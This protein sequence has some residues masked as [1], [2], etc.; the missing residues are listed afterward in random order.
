[1]GSLRWAKVYHWIIS[2]NTCALPA[3]RQGS[4][5]RLH[6]SQPHHSLLPYTHSHTPTTL[7]LTSLLPSLP[8]PQFSAHCVM[9][10]LGK[11]GSFPHSAAAAVAALLSRCRPSDTKASSV[12]HAQSDLLPGLARLAE[13]LIPEAGGCVQEARKLLYVCKQASELLHLLCNPSSHRIHRSYS[14]H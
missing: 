3:G 5:C 9:L 10:H 7:G 12:D 1:M 8:L 11:P 6:N 2:D 4:S 13:T 14:C